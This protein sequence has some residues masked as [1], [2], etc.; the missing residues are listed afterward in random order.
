MPPK[1]STT[2]VKHTAAPLVPMP[3]AS[4]KPVKAP[5]AAKA[6]KEPKSEKKKKTKRKRDPNAPKKP[7]SAYFYFSMAQRPLIKKA[8]P[9]IKFGD[10][11]KEI[12]AAWKTLSDATKAKFQAAADNDKLR[13]DLEM[14]SYKPS[15]VPAD[16]STDAK[17]SK[18]SAAA[19]KTAAKKPVAPSSD[20]EDD[21][22]DNEGSEDDEEDDE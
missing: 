5:K 3:T 15:G 12:G 17:K 22:E 13:Y 9:D 2:P 11:G 4:S 21:E 19:S 8:N 6:P 18:T 16:P 10:I 7:L 14:K 1:S 20:E